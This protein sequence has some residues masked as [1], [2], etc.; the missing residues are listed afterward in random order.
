VATQ[1]QQRE[2]VGVQRIGH[3]VADRRRVLTRVGPVWAGAARLQLART[4]QQVGARAAHVVGHLRQQLPVQQGRGV[5][6]L[7]GDRVQDPVPFGGL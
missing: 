4:G 2:R 7:G 6:D 3:Q 5:A 1:Q